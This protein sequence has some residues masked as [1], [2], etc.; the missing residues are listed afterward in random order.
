MRDG[1]AVTI[2]NPSNNR[3]Y[4]AEF[5]E[6]YEAKK[7]AGEPL[8]T[9]LPVEE[10]ELVRRRW[11]KQKEEEKKRERKEKARRRSQSRGSVAT[12]DAP[13]D[14]LCI[15]EGPSRSRSKSAASS[16]AASQPANE[17]GMIT[18]SRASS[19]ASRSR[20]RRGSIVP[21]E[22]AVRPG[23]QGSKRMEGSSE[24]VA[25]E[26]ERGRKRRRRS[27]ASAS[28]ISAAAS[29]SPFDADPET[30]FIPYHRQQVK[31][32]GYVMELVPSR[33]GEGKSIDK[34]STLCLC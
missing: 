8:P 27:T 6:D 21:G 13:A 19:M 22:T 3:R 23:A 15:E 9:K 20:S 26:E 31:R 16:K 7:A 1:L 29:Q 18:R 14:D 4:L 17:G 33:C 24:S 28:K 30:S 10:R 5:L 11:S 34:L 12:Q 32:A 2:Q 25:E